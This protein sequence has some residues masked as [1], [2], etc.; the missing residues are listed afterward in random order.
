M[1]VALVNPCIPNDYT[2][3]LI[4]HECATIPCKCIL[5]RMAE[6]NHL[7]LLSSWDIVEIAA[8]HGVQQV[9][10]A[11]RK[12]RRAPRNQPKWLRRRP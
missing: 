11:G 4:H 2:T 5:K 1:P 8:R 9:E 7:R 3:E 6:Q 10:K 12:I